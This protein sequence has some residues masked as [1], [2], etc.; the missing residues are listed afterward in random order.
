MI[1]VNMDKAKEIWKDKLRDARKPVLER[2]DV[3]YIRAQEQNLDVADIVA[4][5]QELRDITTAPE[6]VN[7]QTPEELKSFWPAILE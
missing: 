6:I 5:K 1:T 7:A 3:E 4:Q 2:L